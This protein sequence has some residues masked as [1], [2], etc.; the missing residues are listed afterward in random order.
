MTTSDAHTAAP[1]PAPTGVSRR[2][3]LSGAAAIGVAAVGMKPTAAAATEVPGVPAAGPLEMARLTT[4]YAERLLGTDVERPRLGWVLSA[5]GHGARQTGYRLQVATTAAGFAPPDIWDSG[6]VESDASVG[7]EYG[8][9][10]L[11]PRTRYF[12]RVKV[13][14]G[15]GHESAWSEPTWFETALRDPSEWTGVWIGAAPSEVPPLTFEGASWIWSPG[16]TSENAPAGTR[17]FRGRLALPAGTE[18]TSARVVATADDD[19]TLWLDG[20]QTLY[21]PQQVDGWRSAKVADVTDR[22]AALV[23]S[24]VVVAAA[25]TNRPGPSINPGGL[26]AK[27]VVTTADGGEIVLV[28]DDSWVVAETV[29]AGWEAPAFDDAGWVHAVELAPY[30]QGPWGSGVTVPAI[31]D[32]RP[33]LDGATWIWS[34]DATVQTAPVG[35]RYFRARLPLASDAPVTSA[36]LVVTADD[37]FTLWLD[38][39]QAL[40]APQQTDGWKVAREADVTEAVMAR[41]GDAVTVAVSATNRG[42]STNPAGL[43]GKLVVS[44][45]SGE[46]V[47]LVTDGRW[48]VTDTV[49]AGWQEP[50][51]DDTAWVAA[52]ELAPYGQGP[53]GTNVGLP[54]PDQPA[55]LLRRT[56]TLDKPVARARLYAS[57]LAYHEL[58]LDGQR[59][60]RDVL[61]PG[62]TDYDQT[63]LYVTHDVTE[64]LSAGEH[65]V[66]VELGRGFFGMTTPNAWRWHQ[67]PWHG[68]PRLLLQL[69]VDHPDGTRTTIGSDLDWRV[70]DGPTRSDSLYAGETYDARF[71]QPGWAA[72]G[73]DDSTWAPVA[74]LEGPKGRLVAQQHEPIRVLEDVPVSRWSNPSEGQWVADFGRTMAGWARLHVDLP[75]GVVVGL[76]HGERLDGNGH[77]TSNNGLISG[78]RSQY[79]EFVS[80]G[81][82]PREWEPR[83]SYKGFRYVQ[84]TGLPGRPADGAV[85]A[86]VVGSDVEPISEFSCSDE[87]FETFDAA[88]RRTIHNNLH[89]IPTD[90][91]LYEKNGWTGDAQ[92]GAITMAHT[93]DLARFFTKW[94]GDIADSQIGSGQVPVIVPSG[95]WGYNELAPAPEWTTVFPFLVREMHRWYGDTRLI[96]QHWDTLV[97]Y[98]DWE[99]GRLQNGLAVTAL[100]DYLSPG[101]GGNPPEDTRLTATAFLI[102]G[103]RHTAEAGELVGQDAD[104]TR[105]RAAADELTSALNAAFLDRAAGHYRTN[106]DP[107]Y[108][109]TSN[110]IPLA[111]G[112]VP[113]DM[114]SSVVES[115]VADIRSRGMHL[116]TGNLGTEVLLPVLTDHGYADVATAVA[117]QTTYPS[118]GYWFENGADTMW[119]FWN[120]PGRSRNHYF[121][122][123]V[124]EWLFSHVAGLRPDDNGWKRTVVRPAA[125][126]GLSEA[127]LSVRTVR[128]PVAVDWI[129]SDAVMTMDVTVPVSGTAEV[130]V[131]A[132]TA[133]DVTV[134][135]AAALA[136]ARVEDG[137]VVFE[138]GAGRWR[139]VS[140]SAV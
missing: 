38:G 133:A 130:H 138:V 120:L 80:D 21:A 107:H 8:G 1:V 106:R 53:W 97:G 35:T 94:L 40:A 86:R 127:H 134:A 125:H 23:G 26:L 103:L 16:A 24:E 105:F 46:D 128:G 96:S 56:F 112:L 83:F 9:P 4:E 42:Q 89:G 13:W 113:D 140:R 100:G 7:V 71:E 116:N 33:D 60:G 5:E 30:G 2:V 19:F 85:V 131:P 57:G 122:G 90:T 82:G 6:R 58:W 43:V 18:V 49:P 65:V 109:Q 73:F 32:G 74:E 52:A 115:L 54:V 39:T 123:T 110:A 84:V 135:P 29:Q 102:R 121:Q 81:A 50:G 91:P 14:D 118:W 136:P 64:A 22:V 48:R 45:S 114:V 25:A 92:V 28:S 37:D 27:L 98:L 36:R 88:M 78:G 66:G 139:F 47:V 77:V 20:R 31:G 124:V 68:D 63:V 34:P 119:E 87:L 108:R 44:L 117:R 137:F 69:E 61:D 17:Y 75:E 101:T 132:R 126:A 72:P 93:F 3:F 129:R 76:R 55:P 62:F 70:T 10:A 59:I 111:F 15:A 51:F 11:Q 104:A 79:D 99:L 95:D 41:S 12:W 67:P